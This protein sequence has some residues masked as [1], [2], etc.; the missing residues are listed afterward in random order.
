[1]CLTIEF[2]ETKNSHQGVRVEL[3]YYYV[4]QQPVIKS[5]FRMAPNGT[6]SSCSLKKKHT[7][8]SKMFRF[9]ATPVA[10]LKIRSSGVFASTMLQDARQSHACHLTQSETKKIALKEHFLQQS[11]TRTVHIYGVILGCAHDPSVVG[12]C[13]DRPSRPW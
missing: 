1:M 6:W 12:D 9:L 2:R 5:L 4:M 3:L 11:S 13:C 8:E 7:N 10:E